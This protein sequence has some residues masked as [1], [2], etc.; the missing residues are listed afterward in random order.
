M[1]WVSTG[2]EPST[3]VMNR[4]GWCVATSGELAP[5]HPEKV[6]LVRRDFSEER[7]EEHLAL[8]AALIEACPLDVSIRF[9]PPVPLDEFSDRKALARHGE[10]QI[11]EAVVALLRGNVNHG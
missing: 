11:R 6:L 3:A 4:L 10:T 9:G 8:V 5:R 1:T 2:P 7:A